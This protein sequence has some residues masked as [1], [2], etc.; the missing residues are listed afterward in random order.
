MGILDLLIRIRPTSRSAGILIVGLDNAG[1]TSILRQL[2]DEDVS[3][4]ASTQGFQIKKLITGRMKLNV[5]DMGGQR[6]A[7]YYWRQYFE[8]ADVIIY[9]VDAADPRRILEARHELEHLLE[10]E[11][12]AG[13]P[14][15][16]FA[17]KQDLL[18]AL[19]VEEL[20][21]ALNLTGLRDRRWCI[22]ACSA[23]TGE[24]LDKGINWAVKQVKK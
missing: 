24:G 17:N 14:M 6:A 21:V 18:G 3:H 4:V 23:K 5:W 20:T 16:I 9:V 1:K 13:V 10:E 19:S 11:K 15:L 8:E 2:S 22:Q 7:R 12:V